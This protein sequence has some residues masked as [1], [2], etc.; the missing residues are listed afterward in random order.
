M[1]LALAPPTK[2]LRAR[3]P[4]EILGPKATLD[5]IGFDLQFRAEGG[6]GSI[7]IEI[8]RDDTGEDGKVV[9]KM[10]RTYVRKTP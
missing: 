3:T 10:L 1:S 6:P 9:V 2:S 5:L 7:V 8:H 4:D